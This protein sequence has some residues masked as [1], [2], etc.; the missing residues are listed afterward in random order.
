[1]SYYR[2]SLDCPDCKIAL[3]VDVIGFSPQWDM[4]VNYHCEKCK[5]S[6]GQEFDIAEMV[7]K[8]Q[9]EDGFTPHS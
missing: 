7:T 4:A 5:Q 2:L 9:I 8:A 1:M 6:G 3:T